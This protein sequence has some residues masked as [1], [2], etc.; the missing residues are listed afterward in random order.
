[1]K[2]I[3][4]GDQVV[5]LVGKDKNHRGPVLRVADDRVFVEGANLCK[6]HIKPDPRKEEAHGIRSIE[7]SIH[8]SN[9]A[10][11]NHETQKADR[12]GFKF[13]EGEG[14][15]DRKKIRYFKSNGIPVDLS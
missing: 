1:M 2:R 9:V 8:I 7:C 13:V 6:K 4:K 11:I 5:V 10:L 14:Q 12:V 3:K 15:S